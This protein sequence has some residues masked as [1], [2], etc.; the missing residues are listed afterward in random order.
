MILCEPLWDNYYTTCPVTGR[1]SQRR[2]NLSRHRERFTKIILN[3][4]LPLKLWD[5][6]KH[7]FNLFQTNN[8][9]LFIVSLLTSHICLL[10]YLSPFTHLQNHTFHL[11]GI[12]NDSIKFFD[13]IDSFPAMLFIEHSIFLK[14][15]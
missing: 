4:V 5:I 1:G 9:Q 6:F 3:I 8:N 10:T 12:V 15:S 7:D 13:I 11:T 2:H 14:N